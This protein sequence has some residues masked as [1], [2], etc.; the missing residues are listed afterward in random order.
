[1]GDKDKRYSVVGSS[2][3]RKSEVQSGCPSVIKPRKG[4]DSLLLPLHLK[5]VMMVFGE[6]MSLHYSAS[7]PVALPLEN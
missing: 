3:I 1:M 6:H 4:P 2:I 5:K 7:V